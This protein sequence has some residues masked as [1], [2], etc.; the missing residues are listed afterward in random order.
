MTSETTPP[1]ILTPETPNPF[2]RDFEDQSLRSLYRKMKKT[3]FAR[4]ECAI[5]IRRHQKFSLW[6]ISFFSAGLI[7]FPVIRCFGIPIHVSEQLFNV[8]QV[9]LALL[10]LVLSLLIAS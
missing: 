4:F 2:A 6:T 7:I 10:V 5:R 1:E 8:M 3:A 9:V